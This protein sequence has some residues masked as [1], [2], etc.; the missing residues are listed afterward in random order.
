LF[1]FVGVVGFGVFG[2]RDTVHGVNLLCVYVDVGGSWVRRTEIFSA[3]FSLLQVIQVLES[4]DND[5][6]HEGLPINLV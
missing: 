3:E 4:D 5:I 6:G 2:W 1:F